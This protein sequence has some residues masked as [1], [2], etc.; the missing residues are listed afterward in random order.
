MPSFSSGLRKRDHIPYES[1]SRRKR[2]ESYIDVK[3]RVRLSPWTFASCEDYEEQEEFQWS[4]IVFL[5]RKYPLVWYNAY[6]ATVYEQYHDLVKRKKDENIEAFCLS[7]GKYPFELSRLEFIPDRLCGKRRLYR[8][9]HIEERPDWLGGKTVFEAGNDEEERLFA[10]SATNGV[11]LRY[12]C[13]IDR[14]FAAGIGLDIIVNQEFLTPDIVE[15]AV[16]NFLDGGE[17]EWESAIQPNPEPEKL[18]Q[19]LGYPLTFNE[20]KRETALKEKMS[21][22]YAAQNGHMEPPKPDETV[23]ETI[24]REYRNQTALNAQLSMAG[25]L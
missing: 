12:G 5:S 23:K 6:I 17:E 8:M 25:I 14:T 13:R 2:R 21:L 20:V 10:N 22:E 11:E 7:H 3:N 15:T 18:R 9:E 24:G 4:D 19:I 1:L 16:R